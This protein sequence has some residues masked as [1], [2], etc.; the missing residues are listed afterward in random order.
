[1]AVAPV[2]QSVWE[3]IVGWIAAVILVGLMIPMG[4]ILYMD[5]LQVKNDVKQQLEK[6]EKLRRQIEAQQRKD[7]DK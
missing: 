5:I 3:D 2:R 4:A 6:V 7:K 1:V